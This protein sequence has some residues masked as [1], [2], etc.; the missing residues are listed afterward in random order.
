MDTQA[1]T[2]Q[3]KVSEIG[4]VD[5]APDVAV[6]GERVEK[7]K[8][9]DDDPMFVTIEIEEGMSKS[10]RMWSGSILRSIAE[11]VNQKLPVGYQGHIKDEDDA[12]AFPDPQIAWLGATAFQDNGKTKVRVKGYVLSKEAKRLLDLGVLTEFSVRGN[13]KQMPMVGGGVDIRQFD[14]ETIDFARPNRGGM[15]TRVV[16]IASE[17]EG[18]KTVD[19]KEIAALTVNDLRTHNPN[20]VTQIENA[21][22]ADLETKVSE[23]ETALEATKEDTTLLQSVRTTLGLDEN[24]DILENLTAIM[25]RVEGAVRTEVRNFIKDK[26]TDKVKG[27]QEQKLV[28]RMVGEMTDVKAQVDDDGKLTAETEKALQTKLDEAFE[29]DEEVK[30]IVTEQITTSSS[31]GRNL[32]GQR[33]QERKDNSSKLKVEEKPYSEATA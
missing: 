4:A 9:T 17:M 21:A 30:A 8:A 1:L 20:V 28:L 14:L 24:G 3:F 10:K 19:E 2:E 25:D 13:A 12:F 15:K 26:I 33:H 5:I 7:I 22:K 29:N 31:G 6:S 32:G 23:Q 11:Q 16:K 27:E 18:G